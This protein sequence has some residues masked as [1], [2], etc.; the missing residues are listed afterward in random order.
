MEIS[1][2]I[3]GKRSYHETTSVEEEQ[4]NEEQQL[5]KVEDI[6]FCD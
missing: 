2:S 4:K 1:N 5:I 6:D 3:L